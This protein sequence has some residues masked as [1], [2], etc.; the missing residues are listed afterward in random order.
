M[1]I[2]P[3][4]RPLYDRLRISRAKLAYIVDSTAAPVASLAPIGTWIGAE[5]GYIEDGLK[6]VTASAAHAGQRMPE[7]LEGMT[8]YQAFLASIGYRFYAIFAL[9]LVLIIALMR[10]DLMLASPLTR[11]AAATVRQFAFSTAPQSGNA[12]FR[13]RKPSPEFLSFVFWERIVLTSVATGSL[14]CQGWS[15]YSE[16]FRKPTGPRRW[17]TLF[18]LWI[19]EA[20]GYCCRGLR[21]VGIRL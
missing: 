7:F 18:N 16:R 5:I 15:P 12:A 10:R 21:V 2:G 20:S 19:C 14:G 9:V 11:I 4:L 6:S 3:T 17:L 1:I 13:R 8:A